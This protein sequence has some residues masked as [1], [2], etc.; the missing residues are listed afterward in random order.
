MKNGVFGFFTALVVTKD[1]SLNE[2]ENVSSKYDVE[3]SVISENHN[4]CKT[5]PFIFL[6]KTIIVDF[7]FEN[8]VVESFGVYFF[9]GE[10]G[11]S[12][13]TEMSEQKKKKD[14]DKW[15]KKNIGATLPYEFD[16]GSIV[17]LYDQ[18]SGFSNIVVRY[19]K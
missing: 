19:C 1:L 10:E 17:S 8:G 12:S 14:Q 18:K 7:L 2:I 13:D 6:G 3:C 5:K 4:S 11:W 16:W 9:D 15:L